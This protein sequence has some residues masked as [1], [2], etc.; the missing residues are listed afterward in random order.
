MV[1]DDLSIQK[2]WSRRLAESN[3][4]SGHCAALVDELVKGVLTI[5]AGLR[6]QCD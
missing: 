2:H 3:E 6:G 5:R 1:G 4:L